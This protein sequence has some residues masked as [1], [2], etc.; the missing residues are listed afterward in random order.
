M[1]P[2]VSQKES[3]RGLSEKRPLKDARPVGRQSTVNAKA[4]PLG[5][6]RYP[7]VG[8]RVVSPIP[9]TVSSIAFSGAGL[10]NVEQSPSSARPLHHDL[11]DRSRTVAECSTPDGV[12]LR[13][14]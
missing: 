14:G 13:F 12:V 4:H 11:S 6:R 1:P 8:R 10:P 7:R 5:R 2:M 9:S 3:N